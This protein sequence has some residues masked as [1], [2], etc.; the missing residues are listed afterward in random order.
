MIKKS[1]KLLKENN[2]IILVY[3][4]FFA[5]TALIYF[6]LYPHNMYDYIQGESFDI[7][8]YMFAMMK[9][10]IASLLMCGL[11]LLFISGYGNMMAEAIDYGKTSL[12]SFFPG[13]KKFFVRVLLMALLSGAIVFG[14]SIIIGIVSV[15]FA[16]MMLALSGGDNILIV[17]IVIMLITVILLILAMPF[18]ILWLPSIFLD[19]I[20]IIQGLKNGFKAGVKNYGKLVLLLLVMYLPFFIYYIFAYDSLIQGK[21]YTPGY[22]I[23][24]LLDAI[25]GIVVLPISFLIYKD[26]KNKA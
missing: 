11:S 10:L 25:V 24:I 22:Y 1:I 9:M 26:Y 2:S 19:N 13:I 14:F 7:A 15:L 20:K 4:I 8:G 3:F 16:F 5:I 6:S 23:I 21:I 18:I 17:S 12:K